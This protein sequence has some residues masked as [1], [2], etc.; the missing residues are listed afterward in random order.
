M[1]VAVASGSLNTRPAEH[2]ERRASH[3]EGRQSDWQATGAD[4]ACV[5]VC[6]SSRLLLYTVCSRLPVICVI[7][8]LCVRVLCRALGSCC[9]V[10]PSVSDEAIRL[11]ACLCVAVLLCPAALVSLCDRAVHC[12]TRMKQQAAEATDNERSGE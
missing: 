2:S 10:L 5:R 6:V 11:L 3:E 7:L 9:L 4:F 8:Y 12:C 1:C